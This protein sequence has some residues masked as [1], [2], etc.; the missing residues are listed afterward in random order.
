MKS[1]TCFDRAQKITEIGAA[2][3]YAEYHA[4]R[5]TSGPA[6]RVLHDVT[7]GIQT[8]AVKSRE[9]GKSLKGP[10]RKTMESI[11]GGLDRLKTRI[12]G[13]WSTLSASEANGIRKETQSLRKQVTDVWKGLRS[14]CSGG[15]RH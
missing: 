14:S 7:S 6:P 3:A 8:A 13:G 15:G 2:L 5:I 12:E 10:E 4:E 9:L 11:A 1:R